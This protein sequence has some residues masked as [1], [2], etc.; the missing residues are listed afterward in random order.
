MNKCARIIILV[1]HVLGVDEVFS[2]SGT[3]KT[4]L[5]SSKYMDEFGGPCSLMLNVYQGSFPGDK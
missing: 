5:S 4:F 3:G 1:V 2:I